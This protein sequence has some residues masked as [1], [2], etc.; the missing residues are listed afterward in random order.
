MVSIKRA[1]LITWISQ[2]AG[3][4]AVDESEAGKN[5]L[6]VVVSELH[7]ISLVVDVSFLFVK[8]SNFDLLI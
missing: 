4:C 6:K 7:L 8:L 2:L 1:A 3:G 5:L